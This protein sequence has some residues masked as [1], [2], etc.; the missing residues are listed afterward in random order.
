MRLQKIP[1][2]EF[3]AF[4]EA[5]SALGHRRP[6]PA[7]APPIVDLAGNLPYDVQRL[8]HETWDDVVARRRKRATLDDLHATLNRL[9]AEQ[10]HDVRN[11]LAAPHAG[12]RGAL[13]AVVFEQ[14]ENCW[15]P[16]SA[17]AI[18]SAAR[19]ASRRRWRRCNATTSSRATTTAGTPSSTR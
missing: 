19:R 5:A 10:R 4:V 2:D 18:G 9:L 13:R 17:N 1:A 16:T 3:A 7:S 8:A 6:K 14:G 11:G 15:R 12:Q